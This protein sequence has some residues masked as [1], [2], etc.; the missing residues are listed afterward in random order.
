[1]KKDN[2][3]IV[4][5]DQIYNKMASSNLH[6]CKNNPNSFS[7]ICGCTRPTKTSTT[8][9]QQSQNINFVKQAYKSCISIFNL[10]TKSGL[11]ILCAILVMLHKLCAIFV[12][13]HILCAIFVKR[14]FL[15]GQKEKERIYPK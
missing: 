3:V 14:V 10:V 2:H 7:Y 8:L 11:H 5:L 4:F 6:K 13:L 1:M 9:V 15:I 12:M